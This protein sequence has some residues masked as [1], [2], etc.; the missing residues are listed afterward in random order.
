MHMLQW[1]TTCNICVGVSC[2]VC[3]LYN[4]DLQNPDW[5]S[6]LMICS[7]ASCSTLHEVKRKIYTQRRSH[8]TRFADTQCYG[9]IAQQKSI[10]IDHVLWYSVGHGPGV[11]IHWFQYP[12]VWH[13]YIV[14][15]VQVTHY[16]VVALNLTKIIGLFSS[17]TAVAL[18]ESRKLII[19]VIMVGYDD[20]IE[21]WE[22]IVIFFNRPRRCV[23]V[24]KPMQISFSF[25]MTETESLFRWWAQHLMQSILTTATKKSATAIICER[26]HGRRNNNICYFMC[27]CFSKSFLPTSLFDL[28]TKDYGERK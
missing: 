9:S 26:E 4:D 28:S 16:W 5:S 7:I 14:R 1:S 13:T 25:S 23:C 27:S 19:A 20:R 10:A 15:L 6:E 2:I 8:F 24:M 11:L 12:I 17:L 3:H 21:C 22:E 18:R